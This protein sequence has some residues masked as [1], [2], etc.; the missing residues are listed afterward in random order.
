MWRTDS[1]EKTL[2]LGRIE[3][4]R[5]RGW[6]R[7]R[8]LNDITDLMDLSLSK[9]WELVMDSEAWH[10]AVHGISKSHSDWMTELS[11]IDNTMVSALRTLY[12]LSLTTILGDRYH[13]Y[14]PFP[15]YNGDIWVSERLS[16]LPTA[17]QL[18]GARITRMFS[19][20]KSSRLS[21]SVVL[22]LVRL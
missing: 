20:F 17:A 21:N 22:T 19:D 18:G 6:Q 9:L 14:S 3:G 7:T 1:L 13:Y 5:T 16:N 12:C 10:A 11:W 4:R 15:L 2:I 8:W